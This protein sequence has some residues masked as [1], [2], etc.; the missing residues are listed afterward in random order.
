MD[1]FTEV[2]VDEESSA[3]SKRSRSESEADQLAS[4]RQVIGR[5]LNIISTLNLR[6]PGQPPTDCSKYG[7]WHLYTQTLFVS[8]TFNTSTVDFIR[9]NCSDTVQYLGQQATRL[10]TANE[11]GWCRGLHPSLLGEPDMSNRLR[12]RLPGVTARRM[13]MNSER[14][15]WVAEW[16]RRYPQLC[17]SSANPDPDAPPPLYELNPPDHRSPVVSLPE[18]LVQLQQQLHRNFIS[19]HQV[20]HYVIG[21]PLRG[22]AEQANSLIKLWNA[23]QHR[24]L[25]SDVD[26][27]DSS[28]IPADRAIQSPFAVVFC[29]S[30]QAASYLLHMIRQKAPHLRVSGLLPQVRIDERTQIAVQA[31]RH[32]L[33]LLFCSEMASR[34]L[35]L[36]HLTHVINIG[37]PPNTIAYLHRAGRIGRLG[38]PQFSEVWTLVDDRIRID[39]P[40]S[41]ESAA[42]VEENQTATQQAEF[43]DNHKMSRQVRLMLG[44]EARKSLQHFSEMIDVSITNIVLQKSKL[45]G[46]R[47]FTRTSAQPSE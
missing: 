27:S 15:D 43:S 12:V 14:Q 42:D 7:P 18:Q 25:D 37:C 40:D 21:T 20:H 41:S 28:V 17:D 2:E 32:K 6:R 13:L 35:N 47:P 31:N 29:H 5:L 9:K 24:Q 39:G 33:D 11:L 34:G 44:A 26:T 30:T 19:G 23:I 45:L 3:E 1:E 8:A 22:G 36:P 16:L 4:N 10:F 46:R 38:G